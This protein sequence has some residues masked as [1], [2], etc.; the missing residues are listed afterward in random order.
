MLEKNKWYRVSEHYPPDN[1]DLVVT[2]PDGCLDIWMFKP[3][4]RCDKAHPDFPIWWM[5]LEEPSD[6]T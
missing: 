5:D 2:L 6:G 1:E 3:E 4:Y